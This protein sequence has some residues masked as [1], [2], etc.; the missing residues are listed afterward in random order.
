MRGKVR[1]SLELP[2]W[3]ALKTAILSA[4]LPTTVAKMLRLAWTAAF[5]CCG[6]NELTLRMAVW[7]ES[8]DRFV[9]TCN[10][11]AA[12]PQDGSEPKPGMVVRRLRD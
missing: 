6:A 4:E 11:V 3:R 1:N 2:R 9:A 12:A 7:A 8:A 5:V 10:R